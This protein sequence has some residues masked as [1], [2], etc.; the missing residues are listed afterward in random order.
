MKRFFLFS[1]FFS[2]SLILAC[3]PV[4]AADAGTE[5]TPSPEVTEVVEVSPSPDVL[6]ESVSPVT[7]DTDLLEQQLVVLGN[8]QGYLIAGLVIV[9]C[10]FVYK[11][12]HMF[13]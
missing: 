6:V 2:L 4:L 3:G 12:F 8:I 1:F 13:F 11:F 9:L 10:F 5:S 7:S